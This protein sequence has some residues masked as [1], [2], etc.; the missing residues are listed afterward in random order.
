MAGARGTFHDKLI[1]E[2]LFRY[3]D[4][5]GNDLVIAVSIFKVCRRT[6]YY[7]KADPERGKLEDG[8]LTRKVESWEIQKDHFEFLSHY[9][10]SQ[11]S[12][13]FQEGIF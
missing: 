9:L 12:R 11:E 1:R 10:Q 2:L 4:E 5:H 3:L 8:R 7:W 13:L 6:I